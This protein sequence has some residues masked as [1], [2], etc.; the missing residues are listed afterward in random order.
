MSS[1]NWLQPLCLRQEFSA[2]LASHFLTRDAY[3][4]GQLTTTHTAGN[5]PNVLPI[6]DRHRPVCNVLF[7]CP[8]CER[9]FPTKTKLL[10]HVNTRHLGRRYVC[11]RCQCTF[12]TK[13]GLNSHVRHM[14]E[15]LCRYTCELCGKGYSD[16]SNYRDHIATHAGVKR[17]VC[18]ICQKQFTFKNGLKA[19]MLYF[20]T[21]TDA[22]SF[23]LVWDQAFNFFLLTQ[24]HWHLGLPHIFVTIGWFANWF[25][26]C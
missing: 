9:K 13:S 20:H 16:G 24:I 11:A 4:G 5:P 3:K 26:S 19:H 7:V 18:A 10:Y 12:V 22:W 8:H 2:G 21:N 6:Q 25:D 1:Y 17:N 23:V 14:H 15:K